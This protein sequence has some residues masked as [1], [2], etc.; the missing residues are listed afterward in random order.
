MKTASLKEIRDELKV[1][2]ADQLQD[3]CLRLV[4]F[5][6]ENKELLA[7]L[8]FEAENEQNFIQ[9]VKDEMD[10]AFDGIN[11]RNTFFIRKSL[12]KILR[13]TNKYIKFSGIKTTELDLA[14]HFCKKIRQSKIPLSRHV[15]LKNLYA[16]QVM[17]IEKTLDK[18]HEDVQFD[19]RDDL[20]FLKA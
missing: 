3:L 14:I 6:K 17:R 16:R 13:D 1:Y 11:R 19:Y 5:K 8:L 18:L 20:A 7:Y 12:R 4:K 2:Q 9:S 10:A 15:A